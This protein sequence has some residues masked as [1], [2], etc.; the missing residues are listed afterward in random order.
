MTFWA[1]V[2]PVGSRSLLFGV[3]QFL[4]HPWIVARAWR[5]LYGAWPAWRVLVCIVIHDWGYFG[6]TSMDDDTGELHPLR[7]ARIAGRFFGADY[8]DLVLLHS[9]HLARRLK[10]EP[11][12]LCWPDKLS[13]LYDWPHFYL[14]RARLSGELAEYRQNTA[15]AGFVPLT[16]SDE[17]WFAW[18]H[19]Y[20]AMAARDRRL[21]VY[22][23]PERSAVGD[24]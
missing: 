17:V 12:A 24:Q 21:Q 19:E 22:V 1:R 16:A 2:F 15:R 23:N 6:C 8:R 3:H 10:A 20:F 11:S 18:L 14:F 7:G 13:V 5:H 4:W 9:R